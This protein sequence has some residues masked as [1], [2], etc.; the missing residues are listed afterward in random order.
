MRKKRGKKVSASAGAVDRNPITPI[1]L[2]P[3]YRELVE[4]LAQRSGS[5]KQAVQDGLDQLKA[6][7]FPDEVEA[8]IEDYK[9]RFGLSRPRAVE[10]LLLEAIEL[11]ARRHIGYGPSSAA[12]DADD[13]KSVEEQMDDLAK[14]VLRQENPPDDGKRRR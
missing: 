5:M 3:E 13:P 9:R 6:N 10:R 7:R 4:R 12:K 11:R 2:D 1:R 14:H 8:M